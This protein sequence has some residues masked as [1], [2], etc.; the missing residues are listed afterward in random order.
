[1]GITIPPA[2]EE[3]IAK[4]N[5][6]GAACDEHTVHQALATVRNALSNPKEEDNLGAWSEVLAFALMAYPRQSGPWGTYFGPIGSGTSDDGTAWYSPDINDAVP[7]VIHHWTARAKAV[8]HPVLKARYADL[9]WDLSRLVAKTSPHPDMA[10]IAIDAYLASIRDNLRTN[11]HGKFDVTVRALDLAIMIGDGARTDAA[12]N[13]L[14][15]LHREA[16]TEGNGLWWIAF[17]RLINEKRASLTDRE[18]DELVAS[19]EDV[20]T[21]CSTTS[22]PKKFDPH[23]TKSAAERLIKY[24]TRAR[25]PDDVRRLP[26][27]RRRHQLRRAPQ[28][29]RLV[30]TTTRLP[31]RPSQCQPHNLFIPRLRL[32]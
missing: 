6:G 13:T 25:R 17:D 15:A 22:D 24:Y 19:L 30:R 4:I 28:Q 12:R 26:R 23:F 10:K 1:M 16:M 7:E 5:H 20:V 11:L 2:I 14:L 29:R 18:R 21:R 8:T 27:R 3:E 32:A 31:P 9:A